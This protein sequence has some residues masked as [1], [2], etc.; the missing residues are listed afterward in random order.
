MR[1]GA[2][3]VRGMEAKAISGQEGSWREDYITGIH[4]NPAPGLN[5]WSRSPSTAA[6]GLATKGTIDRSN[7]SNARL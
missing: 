3:E 1:G 5:L 7:H 6:M 2:S 4:K